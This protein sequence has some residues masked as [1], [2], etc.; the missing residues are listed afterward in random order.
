MRNQ[1]KHFLLILIIVSGFTYSQS[2][3]IYFSALK[4]GDDVRTSGEYW[5]KQNYGL[6]AIELDLGKRT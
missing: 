2:T 3:A 5:Q 1:I 4:M 6:H